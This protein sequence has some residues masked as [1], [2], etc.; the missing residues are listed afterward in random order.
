MSTGNQYLLLSIMLP[1][2]SVV[3]LEIVAACGRIVTITPVVSDRGCDGSCC[4]R[5]GFAGAGTR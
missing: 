1:L 5:R 2:T 3:L 4:G